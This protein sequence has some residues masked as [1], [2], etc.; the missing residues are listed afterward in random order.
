MPRQ[1]RRES[2]T[3]IYHVMLRGINRQDIFEDKEYSELS[4]PE[5]CRINNAAAKKNLGSG[6][7]IPSGLYK[8]FFNEK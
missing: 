4:S 8:I 3:G 7:R 6:G 5:H 1:A 2:G